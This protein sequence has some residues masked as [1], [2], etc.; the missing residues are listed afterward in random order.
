MT[1]DRRDRGFTL[2]EL[3]VTVLVLGL[4]AA[5]AVPTLMSQRQKA[6]KAAVTAEMRSLRTAQEARSVDNNPRYTANFA[7]LKAEGFHRTDDVTVHIV[8]TDGDNAYVACARHGLLDEWLTYSSVAETTAWSPDDC[9][10]P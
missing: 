1:L 6:A 5:I 8:L 7:L 3:V 2:I 9:A 4:L 10:S